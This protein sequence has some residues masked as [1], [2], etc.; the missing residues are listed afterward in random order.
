LHKKP[1]SGVALNF[2]TNYVNLKT[3]HYVKSLS[4]KFG[5]V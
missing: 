5:I 3:L 4:L 2:G 1:S